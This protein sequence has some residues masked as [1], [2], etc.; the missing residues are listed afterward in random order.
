MGTVGGT[1][2]GTVGG[3]GVRPVFFEARATACKDNI[4][5]REDVQC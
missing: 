5:L 3:T 4:I 1:V 2:V